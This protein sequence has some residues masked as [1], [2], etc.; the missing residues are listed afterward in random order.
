MEQITFRDFAEQGDKIQAIQRQ[1]TEN[2]FTHA[3]MISGEPGT[4]KKTLASVIAKAI[5]C[6]SGKERPCNECENCRLFDSGEHPDMILIQKGNPLAAE[7]RKGRSS[8]P[9]SDI[10]EM[11]RICSQYA[12]KSV[13][14]VIIIQ[15]AENLTVQAQNCLLKIMEDPPLHTYFI[16]TTSKP[17]D[18]LITIRSRC[19]PIKLSPWDSGY[20]IQVL[21]QSGVSSEKARIIAASSSG[22]IG[23]ALQMASDETYWEIRKDIISVF[24]LTSQRSDILRISTAWKDRKE[25]AESLFDIL[26]NAVHHLLVHRLDPGF[27]LPPD[28]YSADWVRFSEEADMERFV[29]LLD[30]ISEA[31]KQCSFNVNFQ[32][33]FEQLHLIFIGER[34]KWAK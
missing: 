28:E 27:P 7:T 9:V 10:R 26:E 22:S 30:Q 5:L 12:Y 21:L 31:K 23:R 6:S 1:I 19:R 15:D 34:E 17:S 3:V 13:N 25:D 16:M 33:L 24:F 14:R 18:V 32:A 29:F 2:Q 8:I 4:G 20:I 11:I